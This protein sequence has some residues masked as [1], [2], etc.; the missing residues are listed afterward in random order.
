MS[1]RLA[2]FA[3]AQLVF[4]ACEVAI[5]DVP[6]QDRIAAHVEEIETGHEVEPLPVQELLHAPELSLTALRLYSLNRS[7]HVRGYLCRTL[8]TLG[9]STPDR[10]TR[11]EVTVELFRL[12]EQPDIRDSAL[13]LLLRFGEQD[14]TASTR[15]NLLVRLQGA[16]TPELLLVAGTVGG[17]AC[18]ATLRK[19]VE[20]P[21][22]EKGGNPLWYAQD[23][24]FATLAL[25]RIGTPEEAR[26]A[27]ELAN[28][29]KNPVVTVGR[30][31]PLLAYTRQPEAVAFIGTFLA[32][33]GRMPG[34][35]PGDRGVAYWQYAVH[36]LAE[37]IPAF[38]VEQKFVGGYDEHDL[39][40]AREWVEDHR[41]VRRTP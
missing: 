14:F 38:S 33:D 18:T 26:R 28:A 17:T 22:A 31:L 3:G 37:N 30:I 39:A 11:Q 4:M 27:V 36:A 32:D 15:V 20:A 5:G 40:A 6:I 21:L 2:F 19:I 1:R 8:A 9:E 13:R 35:K 23:R 24:W 25:A 10:N 29:E 41:R 12:S 16:R 34:V 7:P